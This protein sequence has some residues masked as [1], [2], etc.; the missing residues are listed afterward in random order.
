MLVKVLSTAAK[1]AI[2]YAKS[3][4]KETIETAANAAIL[5]KTLKGSSK[6][7]KNKK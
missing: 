2:K 5:L 3:H 7:D 1:V 4:P 6:D